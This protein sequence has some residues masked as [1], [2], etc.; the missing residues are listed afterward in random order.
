MSALVGS[1]CKTTTIFFAHPNRTEP[2]MRNAA[3]VRITSPRAALR[4]LLVVNKSTALSAQK[5]R[6]P[7]PGERLTII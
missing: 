2:P 3:I 5:P 1:A 4:G 7:P 6:Y